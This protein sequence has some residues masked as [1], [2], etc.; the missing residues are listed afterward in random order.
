MVENRT[1]GAQ[2]NEIPD[3]AITINDDGTQRDDQEQL[4]HVRKRFMVMQTFWSEIHATGL[5]DDKMVAGEQWPEEIRKERQEDRRPILTYNLLPAFNRQIT[6]KIRQERP[7]VKVTPVETNKGADPR[8][9]NMAGTKDYSMAEIYGGIIKNI[10]HTSRADQAYDTAVKHAVDHGFGYFYMLPTWSK[11]DP[12][13]QELRIH[14]V[15]NSYGVMLDPDAQ[16]ADYR[17]MQDAIMFSNMNR[18]T[19][20]AKYP[21]IPFTEFADASMG[22]SYEG[23]YDTESVRLAQYFWLDHKQDEVIL[24]SNGKVVYRSDVEQILDDLERE[25]GVHV[26]KN[27]AGGDMRKAVKR[28]IC[29]WQKMTCENVLE[30]PIE[31]PF[32]SVPIYPVFGEEIIVDGR[33]RYESAIRHAID[34]QKSYNYWRTA[35]TEAVALAPRAPWMI[36]ER[37]LSGHERLYET[38]NVRNLPYLIYNHVDGVPPPQRV[39]AANVAAA[40]LQNATQDGIDMQTIIGL[41]DA[42]LGKESNEKSGKAIIARQNAG[43]TATF[44]FPDNLGR[45]LEQMGRNAVEAIPVITDTRRQVRMRFADSSSDFVEVNQAV[46]DTDTGKEFLLHDIGYGKY[47]VTLE[48]G[49]SYATQRQEAADLQ[50]ELLRVLGPDRAANIVHLIVQNLGVPGSEEVARVLRMMLPDA[51]KTEE[52]KMA[53]LPKGVSK[54]D[55]GNLVDEAG[56]PW[57]PPMTPEMQIQQKTNEIEELRAQAEIAKAQADQ[58]GA[59]ADTKQ[60]EA[61]IAQAELELAKLNAGAGQEGED[62]AAERDQMLA[63][64]TESIQTV[65]RQ[66]VEDA[67]AHDAMDIEEKI[68]AAIVEALT[69]VRGYVDRSV[70]AAGEPGAEPG[71]DQPAAKRQPNGSQSAPGGKQ[72]LELNLNLDRAPTSIEH[73]YDAAGNIVKSVPKYS[74]GDSE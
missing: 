58:A 35:A 44:Q 17:D 3:R 34:P 59:A 63:G 26:Q 54:D 64:I 23:W 14:R 72:E 25:T 67:G 45:A 55:D 69:R 53:D 32:S 70:K 8:I 19:Y 21:N 16:E 50:M 56:E 52:E 30:G 38:A 31:L 27:A 4:E 66:H 39:F 51:L 48:T 41:H 49:P 74:K 40:E 20:K 6:N 43:Q 13:V 2:A 9:A 5:K 7:S 61:K 12:F 33:V 47:D 46:L 71:A 18:N 28:P 29:Q 11:I 1:P 62:Q 42:S 15:K 22:S 36:T 65:M 60:A 68:A 73:E 37:Q 24:L 10:E 57:S